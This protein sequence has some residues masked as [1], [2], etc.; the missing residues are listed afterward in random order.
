MSVFERALR[1]KYRFTSIKG[2]LTSEQVVALPLKARA[3][4]L[5]LQSVSATLLSEARELPQASLVGATEKTP[6]YYEIQHK[7]EFMQQVI[8]DREIFEA[9]AEKRAENARLKIQLTEV[10]AGKKNEAFNNMTAEQLTALIATL[11]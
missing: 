2:P 6:M 5:S 9:K 8:S 3:G 11:E 7:I 4:V 1:K 10:L